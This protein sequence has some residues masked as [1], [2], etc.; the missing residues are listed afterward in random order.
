VAGATENVRAAG[1]RLVSAARPEPQVDRQVGRAHGMTDGEYDRMVDIL[2]RTPTFTELGLFMSAWSEHCSYKSSRIFL[3]TLPTTG[4]CVVQGPGENAGVID[5]GDGQVAAFKMESH[6]HPSFVEPYQGAATGVG[7]ILRDV[8]TMGA[9][10]IASLNALRFGPPSH[11][12]TPFLV[13][14]VVSGIGG[15]GNS[16]GVPTV[17]GDVYFDECYAGNILV[18]AFTLGVAARDKIFYGAASGVS[19]PVLYFG[20]KTGRDGIHGASLLASA[21]FDD[22]SEEKRPTVQVGD[23]FAEKLLLEASLELMSVPGLIVGIQDMGAAGLTSSSVEMAARANNGVDLDLDKVPRREPG[24]TPYEIML[25]ESQERM[26]AVVLAGREQEALAILDKWDIDA[27]LIG[28]VTDTGRV[29][30]R[31]EGQIVADVPAAPLAEGLKYERPRARPAYLDE[32]NAVNPLSAFPQPGPAAFG[33]TLLRILGSPNVASKEWVWRQYDHM[34]RLGAVTRPGNADAAVV[35]V[36]RPDGTDKGIGVVVDCNSRFCYLDP[37]EGSKLAVAECARNLAV[38]GVRPLAVTDCLNFGNP[39]KPEIMWQFA[40]SVRGLSD[41]CRDLETP[42][43]SGNV[44]F[45]NET[46]GRA[47]YP[48]PMIAMV[49]LIQDPSKVVTQGWKGEGDVIALLGSQTMDLG[50]SEY[51]KAIH[52]VVTGHAPRLDVGVERRLHELCILLADRRLVRSAHDLSEGGLAIALAESCITGH[53]P[54]GCTVELPGGDIPEVA[55]LFGESPSRA[56]ISF[57][58]KDRAA[59]EEAAARAGVTFQVLGRTGGRRLKLGAHVDLPLD[60][61]ERAHKEGF[62]RVVE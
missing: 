49:G 48:T 28:V 36:L 45:Y 57:A 15:Y 22:T 29:V 10:P 38:T 27:A 55:N 13:A 7:G 2:G 42:V 61:V 62:R 54:I 20:S 11:P 53:A 52:G 37:Y 24:M 58:E 5:I 16:V 60:T 3:K 44:S 47:I 1:A 18:N 39:E 12:R 51:L 21:E 9:R 56:V 31:A 46:E 23:P 19:N 35:R 17:G 32:L 8:F 4:P 6:N 43:V 25:S 26:L 34:V 14:G 40:E 30:L 50:G 41:A 59:I 33:E